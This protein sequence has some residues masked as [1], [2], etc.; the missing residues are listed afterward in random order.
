MI[1]WRWD[2]GSN[3]KKMSWP[4]QSYTDFGDVHVRA[5]DT[6]RGWEL[7]C[8]IPGWEIRTDDWKLN[9]SAQIAQYGFNLKHGVLHL[10]LELAATP[11]QMDINLARAASLLAS[12]ATTLTYL[13]NKPGMSRLSVSQ[14]V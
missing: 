10:D 12:L 14:A 8:E 4:A 11:D 9:A 2:T 6:G 7:E 1:V 5:L 13:R 3:G